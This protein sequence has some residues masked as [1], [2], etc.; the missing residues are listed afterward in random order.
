LRV[1]DLT[2]EYRTRAGMARAVDGASFDL[3]RMGS[4][5]ILGESGSGKSTLALAIGGLLQPA[6][7]TVSGRAWLDGRDLIAMPDEELQ[8][9]RGRDIGMIFQD[10]LSSLN[11]VKRVGDQV[12]DLFTRHLGLSRKQAWAAA[13]EVLKRVQI[14]NAAQRAGDYPHQFSGGMRQRVMI[15]IALALEPRLVIADEP[16]TALDVTVQAQI[17]DLLGRLRDDVGTTLILISHDLGVAAALASQLVV[18]YGGRFVEVGVLGD[19]YSRPYHPYTQ[20]LM[21]SVPG[22]DGARLVPIP[23]TPPRIGNLPSGC[24]FHPR[25]PFAQDVCRTESPKLIEVTAGRFAACHFAE[26]FVQDG[27]IH[28]NAPIEARHE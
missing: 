17:I 13:V 27:S 16:T 24:V 5:A 15:A 12:A 28:P 23:G 21:A 26:S 4:M 3:P 25:C 19:V 11:P 22:I 6:T 7:S 1:T 14:P 18:M 2:V 10:P 8:D 20:G 9:V